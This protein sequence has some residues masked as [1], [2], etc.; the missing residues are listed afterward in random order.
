[1]KQRVSLA[2]VDQRDAFSLRFNCEYCSYFD[3]QRERCTHGY[4]TDEHRSC[5]YTAPGGELIFCKEFE[6][7]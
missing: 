5:R 7:A 4:P 6:L 1:M 2:F 3:P